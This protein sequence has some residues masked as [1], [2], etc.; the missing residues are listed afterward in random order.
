MTELPLVTAF[1]PAYNMEKYIAAAL[2]SVLAQDYPHVHVVVCDD[3]STD[4]TAEIAS[5]YPGVTLVRQT[6][7][8]RAAACNTAIRTSDGRLLTSFDADDLWPATRV[9]RQVEYLLEHPEAGGV[10]GRQEWMNPPPWLARDVVY[11]DLDGI[12]IGS[13]MLRREVF[14]SVGGFDETFRHGEDMDLVVRLRARGAQLDVLPE[15]VLYRRYHEGQ[16]TANAPTV[17]PLLRSMRE[18]LARERA[19]A[20]AS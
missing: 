14:D 10:F 18:K 7:K 20:E 9:R 11:G 5:S 19:K 6:N 3:G 15:I 17:S 8:G 12:P 16:M 1:M 4:R 2:E 13:V